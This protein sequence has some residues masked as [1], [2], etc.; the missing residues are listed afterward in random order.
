MLVVEGSLTSS[1]KRCYSLVAHNDLVRRKLAYALLSLAPTIVP[2]ASCCIGVTFK[3]F[4][5]TDLSCL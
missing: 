3:K 1:F 2:C 4:C 5:D